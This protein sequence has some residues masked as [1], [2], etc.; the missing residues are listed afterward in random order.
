MLI[1]TT[2]L[3]L[4]LSLV[5]LAVFAAPPEVPS[6]NLPA[7]GQLTW[8]GV[9]GAAGYHVYRGDL[10]LL[11]IGNHG[12][13]LLGSV[14]GTDAGVPANP[15][16]GQGYFFLV[17]AFDESGPGPVGF[18]SSGV[19]SFPNVPCKPN[20]RNFA[21]VIDPSVD[22]LGNAEPARNAARLT[23]GGP[24]GLTHV[25][26]HSGDVRVEETGPQEAPRKPSIGRMTISPKSLPGAGG[27]ED[28]NI[29]IG[30]LQESAGGT[31]D[32][33][34]GIGEM[35]SGEKGGT[36]DINIGVGELQESAGGTEDLTIG[37]GEL[38]E[39][40]G[41]TIDINIGIGEMRSG[42]KGGTED[43]NIGLGELP[44]PAMAGGTMGELGFPIRKPSIGATTASPKK[45]AGLHGTDDRFAGKYYVVGVRHKYYSSGLG[46]D[47]PSGQG[48]EH[49]ANDRLR[50]AGP[51]VG[52][53]NGQG[54][55]SLF[56]PAV[57]PGQW[58]SA[59]LHARLFQEPDGS[60]VLRFPDGYLRR[61]HGFDG[62]NREG[63][64]T[65]AE[66][67][68]GRR[69]SFLYDHQGLLATIVDQ[70]GRSSTLEYDG[71]GRIVREVDFDGRETI[72]TYDAAGN[73]VAVRSPL[74]TG[75]PNG[76]DFTAGKTTHYAYSSGFSS[77]RLNH[78]LIS[79]RTPE[80]GA[81]G[82][83]A[84]QFDYGT[85]PAL[86]DFDRVVTQVVGNPAA[87]P[88]VGGTITYVYEDLNPGADPGDPDI[89]RR[90]TTIIDGN[91]NIEQWVHNADGH[92]LSITE[93]TNRELRPGEPDYVTRHV[94][95]AA[96][97]ILET[98]LPEGNRHVFLWDS[99]ADLYQRGN[100]VQV[101]L[102]ADAARGNGHGGAAPDIVW[103]LGYEPLR[104]QIRSLLTPRG[105]LVLLGHDY[106]E[107]DPSATGL[108]ALAARYRINLTGVPLAV[109]DLNGD[110]RTDQIRGKCVRVDHPSVALD[111]SSRQALIEG[112]TI[113]ES[114]TLYQH[115]D[116]GQLI[117]T[118]DP[119]KNRHTVTYHPETDPDGDGILTPPPADGRTLSSSEG[120]YPHV[121]LWDSFADPGR[122]NGTNPPPVVARVT[123]TYDS[124]GNIK[125]RI[126]PRG[127]A[128]EWIWNQLDQVVE[129]RLGWATF[130]D[131]LYGE[132]G[133]TPLMFRTRYAYDANDNL[134]HV[135]REDVGAT[136]GAG[137]WVDRRFEYDL[138]DNRTADIREIATGLEVEYHYA[139]DANENPVSEVTPEGVVNEMLWDERDLPLISM[140][141][142][143][144]PRGGLPVVRHY[145]YDGNANPVGFIDGRG[146]LIDGFYDGFDRLVRSVDQVGSTSEL[147][148]DPAGN[149]V[150]L[151]ERGPVGGP[152]P[153]DRSGAT[154][155]DLQDALYFY[156][157]R[158]RLIR[159]DR[160]L[161][162]P[163]G[164]L[165]VRPPVILEGPL[166]P[167]DGSVNRVIEYDK[168]SRL[169][170]DHADA[171]ATTRYDYDG[172]GHRVKTTQ[173]D[174]STFDAAWDPAGNLIEE[175]ETELPSLPG[176]PFERFFTTYMYDAL[177]RLTIG[178]DNVGHAERRV[179]DGLGA[180]VA[181]SDPKGPLMVTLPRR[182]ALGSGLFVTVNGHGNV[183]TYQY[184]G[185]GRMIHRERILSA[186]GQGD[187]SLSPPP[188]PTPAN[189]TGTLMSTFN[190]S[191]DSLPTVAVDGTDHLTVYSYD[192]LERLVQRTADD[193]TMT[194][195]SYDGE[196]NLQ[197]TIGADGVVLLHQHDAAQRRVGVSVSNPSG[198]GTTQQTYEYDGLGRLTKATD[199]NQPLDPDD[200]AW[201]TFLYDSLGRRLEETGGSGSVTGPPPA[202]SSMQ[203]LG[204]DRPVGL[205]HP[206]GRVVEYSYDAAGRLTF[207]EDPTA[208]GA[209]AFFEYFG[210]T[211][212]HTRSL[213]NGARTTA[214]NDAGT[215]D[216]GFDGARRLTQLRLLN[217][218]NAVL[219]A[220]EYR[221]DRG[222]N[223]TSQRR[224]HHP[225]PVGGPPGAMGEL[226]Q[227]DSAERLVGFQERFLG[228]DHAPSAPAVD[229]QTWSLDGSGNWAS[230]TRRGVGYLN[231]PNNNNEYDDPQSGGTRVDDGVPDDFGDL[232]STSLPDGVN[233]AHDIEG[234]RTEDGVRYVYDG[235]DRL[236]RTETMAGV[237]LATYSYDALGRRDGR[238]VLSAGVP[239][240][241]TRYWGGTEVAEMESSGL[242]AHE[243]VHAHTYYVGSANGGIWKTSSGGGFVYLIGDALGSTVGLLDGA[244]PALLERVTY[245]PYGKPT[246]ESP[247]NAPLTDAAGNPLAESAHGIPWLFGGMRYDQE[248]G[249]RSSIPAAD[250]GGLY[251]TWHRSYSPNEGRFLTR[252]PLGAWGDPTAGGNAY[253]YAGGNPINATD[254]T[255]LAYFN[256][257][258]V[259]LDKS[260]PWQK[261][262]YNP[263]EVGLDK[264]VP[265]QKVQYNPKEVGLDKSVPWQ[266]LLFNPKEYTVTKATPWKHH[267]IQ[268]L[269]APT[270][271]F[272]QHNQTD[273]DF[274]G[275][276]A[277]AAIQMKR[278]AYCGS[279]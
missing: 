204:E 63:S 1:R 78:N 25:L 175:V 263:K 271:E 65:A 195:Y 129:T 182:S 39:S 143:L 235:L 56:D 248:T 239:V 137:P 47:G 120:G 30:E 229:S 67:P 22:G 186:N 199:D 141:G 207:V 221:Y 64:V 232:A 13:C 247:A 153:L 59:E 220:Y 217:P 167:G 243:V 114:Q 97:E 6:L 171:G 11:G 101:R 91:N 259:G 155:V 115:N 218:A 180:V 256:P 131:T 231:T 245:D 206:S 234:N 254:P 20:R 183:T 169:T 71:N 160:H 121:F 146:G 270:L 272:Y 72:T 3:A 109:G 17:G 50:N 268:G 80:E 205:V 123:L 275:A 130:P 113:Q 36:E 145:R 132:P 168:L 96:G 35:R 225:A 48:W 149:V 27:T 198:E 125:R 87:R 277:T 74:V 222:S 95:N 82:V 139:Y 172:L 7:A 185:L 252:D 179:Y 126:D 176:P 196:G 233:M 278:A 94:Y 189:P 224:P 163:A 44:P 117:A 197:H 83:P 210:M 118:V 142:S 57:L 55:A 253:V 16:V 46:Y 99:A 237:P 105:H 138:L 241:F 223:R 164:S 4:L 127:V 161:F 24:H 214:L 73:R 202:T 162:V 104:N 148:H 116:H 5:P 60:F 8:T 2:R 249:S 90:R 261:V 274:L 158:D 34:I 103:E 240:R 54:G 41:G 216:I 267:D 236:I 112:D 260:V 85:N 193:G 26:L 152:T 135:E 212:V 136:R 29:G 14:V 75:T 77:P 213:R 144:G 86:P 49:R 122:N 188:V 9:A 98:T 33:N 208:G 265:W 244:A 88:P 266:R 177:G 166:D 28:M 211:R 108:F 15:P 51:K 66:S 173:P 84:V 215:A 190:W 184:D 100:M 279:K 133:L 227:Y 70:L 255:G 203:W 150:R 43:I 18:S 23:W 128:T 201:V 257:K 170:F 111:P 38:Q 230:F 187:G 119:E 61:Y 76:N 273:L 251:R 81:S 52:W 151:L 19:E 124:R 156:D 262:Q 269:D 165:P 154:N 40:A 42:E 68:D 45:T 93:M 192:N 178:F 157:E 200:E 107:G 58:E 140:I 37:L 147:F 32:I 242:I 79:I 276:H 12:A 219:A 174:G 181:T 53:F 258:E 264:S 134:V 92:P 69:M 209:S 246:F 10:S 226:Y 21:F 191:D 102:V 228:I 89:E 31:Q 62:S 106:Q 194:V 159:L 110:G 238:Y 250:R